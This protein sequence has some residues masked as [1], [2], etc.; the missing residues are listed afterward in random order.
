MLRD[1]RGWDYCCPRFHDLMV[2]MC[3][4]AWRTGET[5]H[6]GGTVPK[7]SGPG[8]F[9]RRS[10]GGAAQDHRN[11][12]GEP[13]LSDRLFAYYGLLTAAQQVTHQDVDS[14]ELRS[15]W[16][17]VLIE[18]AFHLVCSFSCNCDLCNTDECSGLCLRDAGILTINPFFALVFSPA[19][20]GWK[21][22]LSNDDGSCVLCW[23]PCPVVQNTVTSKSSVSRWGTTLFCVFSAH[24][25]LLVLDHTRLSVVMKYIFIYF[26]IFFWSWL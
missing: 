21:I 2:Q 14:P 22:N 23:W 20:R 9:Q 24:L 5:G 26:V 11:H 3:V 15:S 13:F 8:R 17:V 18:F 6:S 1:R 16:N 25:L 7:S 4:K 19:L 12:T 10:S